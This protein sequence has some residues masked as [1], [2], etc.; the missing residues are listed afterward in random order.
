MRVLET[1]M[2][3]LRSSCHIRMTSTNVK[4]RKCRRA[5]Q[6]SDLHS[7]VQLGCFLLGNR[8]GALPHMAQGPATLPQHSW[9]PRTAAALSNN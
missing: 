8:L 9:P 6:P 4:T 1:D 5:D 3:F 7:G 2:Q